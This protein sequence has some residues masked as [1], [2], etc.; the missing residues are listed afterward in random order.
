[1]SVVCVATTGCRL[2]TE[3]RSAPISV[4]CPLTVACPLETELRSPAMS[5]VWPSRRWSASTANASSGATAPSS[6]AIR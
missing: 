5:V 4:M 6:A 2:E 1:M 3:V